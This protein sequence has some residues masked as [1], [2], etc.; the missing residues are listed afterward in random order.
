VNAGSES[1]MGILRGYLVDL[2]EDGVQRSLR[3]EG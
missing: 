2:T 1:S 3:V